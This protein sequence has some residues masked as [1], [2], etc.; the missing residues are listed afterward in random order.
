MQI[1]II[2]QAN[3]QIKRL[4]SQIDTLPKGSL[5]VKFI[6]G[7]YRFYHN[8]TEQSKYEQ[9][10]L[11]KEVAASL[12]GK[13]LKRQRLEQA[14]RQ[15]RKFR[16]I[17]SDTIE[18]KLKH[19]M[20]TTSNCGLLEY[21]KSITKTLSHF[22]AKNQDL[23]LSE[24]DDKMPKITELNSIILHCSNDKQ[25]NLTDRVSKYEKGN[26]TTADGFRVRS[27]SE[28]IILEQLNSR[29]LEVYYEQGIII[30]NILCYPDFIIRHPV[31]KHF[32][33]WEHCGLMSSQ[34]YRDNWQKKMNTYYQNDIHPCSNLIL[35]YEGNLSTFNAK[36]IKDTIDFYFFR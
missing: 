36:T 5:S 12:A 3:S 28:L 29:V 11:P 30:N 17:I 13:I 2:E 33:I 19:L 22:D 6:S 8:I 27:K 20:D 7:K 31:S 21:G 15:W 32:L 18:S 35:T 16:S 23:L 34:D 24:V 26:I 25:I 9:K 4:Q 1:Q 14:L 10:Y